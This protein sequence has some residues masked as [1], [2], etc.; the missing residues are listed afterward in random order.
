MRKML[1]SFTFS[2]GGQYT[3]VW[4]KQCDRGNIS[5]WIYHSSTW[6]RIRVSCMYIHVCI[7]IFVYLCMFI[8]ICVFVSWHEYITATSGAGSER[9]SSIILSSLALNTQYMQ[10]YA[11]QRVT[12]AEAN[13]L[14]QKDY[15]SALHSRLRFVSDMTNPSFPNILHSC[16]IWGMLRHQ[17]YIHRN[18]HT[19]ISEMHRNNHY[20]ISIDKT[21]SNEQLCHKWHIIFCTGL[22]PMKYFCS[23]LCN[24]SWWGRK[25]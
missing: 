17:K 23:N 14:H 20:W 13:I 1:K 16:I 15:L 18:T 2:R 5:A 4:W 21:F 7:C 19:H 3:S 8:S 12:T 25:V 24:L 9:I 11:N 10:I 22:F 6:C